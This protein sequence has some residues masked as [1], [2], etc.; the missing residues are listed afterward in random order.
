V[1]LLKSVE[2]TEIG[3]DYVNYKDTNNRDQSI[4]DVD[5]IYYATGVVPN[6]ELYNQIKQTNEI[7][8]EK[9]GDARKPETVMEAVSRGYKIGNKV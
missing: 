3:E 2:V 1:N 4:N 7:P 9:I 5:Y 8:I 6:D